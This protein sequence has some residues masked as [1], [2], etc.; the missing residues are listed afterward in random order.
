MPIMASQANELINGNLRSTRQRVALQGEVKS[1]GQFEIAC[2]T[3][4][5]GNGWDFSAGVLQESLSL[6]NGIDC[7]IDH[8]WAGHSI[9]DLAGRIHSPAWSAELSGI[10]AQL[11]PI[12]PNKDLIGEL[13]RE[14]LDEDENT[15]PNIGFS[16]DVLFTANGRKVEKILKV[17][18]VDLVID[19]AR[20]GAFL[21]ALNSR[22]G[23]VRMADEK[24]KTPSVAQETALEK[25]QAA[26]RQLLDYQQQQQ[27]MDEEAEKMKAIRL[28]MCEYLLTSGLAAAKLPA[29]A[30]ERVRKQFAGKVFEPAELTQAIDDSRALVSELTGAMTISGP[31][32]ISEMYTSE[33]HL[34]AAVDDLLGAERDPDKKTI[35]A[36]RLSGVRELY[37]MLTGDVDLH[38][39]Y[40]P[41]HARLATTSDFTGLVKNALNKIV[42]QRWGELGRAG[43]DWWQ[44]VS[45]TEHFG[46]L[47]DITGTLVGT[48]G[49]LPTVAEGAEYTELAIGDS[50]ETASFVKYGGYIPLTL[51]LI[52][53]DETR[54]LRAY[55]AEL[56]AGGLRKISS[57]VAAIFTTASALGPTMADTGT[58]F[59]ATAVTTKGGH[60]NLLTTG[61]SAS[62]WDVV[63]AAV[64]N[65]P[66]LI[67]QETGLYGTGPKMGIN[68]RFCM[69][70]RALELTAKKILYPAWEN[71]ANIHSENVQQGQTG[72]VVV[73]PE[74]TDATDWAAACDPRIAPAIFVGERFGILPEIFIAGDELDPAVFANDEHRLK[75]RHFLAVWVNDFRPLHKSNVAG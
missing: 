6:W 17:F 61:L 50:P 63:S 3:A 40:H 12:G 68:P 69:V 10:T 26:I 72:D 58:L 66:L 39:G 65:Q 55:P 37:L 14:V 21:R 4:G 43:Y 49:T 59:N 41:E 51:E 25:D 54:K 64:Y 29:P 23:G 9:K 31:G 44:R 57:L 7:F 75:V 16:A 73:V 2:I 45:V 27:K 56:A 47:N 15:A 8:S 19:P 46:S 33:D 71:A 36:A 24:D 34:Q 53:R 1:G 13:A 5:I 52:D 62:E 60:K 28:Q 20:G 67:K 74:W 38:G 70:P 48:V 18:S 11:K 42:V 32:R 22:I 30:A 35:K